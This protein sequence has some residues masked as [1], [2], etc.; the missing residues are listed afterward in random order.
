MS[1]KKYAKILVIT[2]IFM[3]AISTSKS[4]AE[5][6]VIKNGNVNNKEIALTF[7]DGYSEEKIRKIV[8]KLNEHGVK[9]TFFFVGSYMASNKEIIKEVESDGHLVVSH[10]FSHPDFTRLT[11]K[12]IVGEIENTKI[13]YTKATDK[14]IPPYFRPPYGAYNDKVL[15]ILG[16]KHDL[17]VVLWDVDTLD[18]KGISAKE[19]SNTVLSNAKNGSIV[20]MHTTQH[21]H[22]DEALDSIITGLQSKGYSFVRIDDMISKLPDEQKISAIEKNRSETQGQSSEI[23]SNMNEI[24]TGIEKNTND[25]NIENT[26]ENSESPSS[27]PIA[28]ANS[29]VPR[30]YLF[31][32]IAN[33]KR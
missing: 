19:I 4:F 22:T 3:M 7:D 14:K 2:L 27:Q 24:D 11:E 18:W 10:S 15:N 5:A 25:V 1:S 31:R 20:L 17:Y 26:D 8:A 33:L 21:V 29:D 12:G 23:S 16:K 6:K 32:L 13:A 9:G 28:N 30:H